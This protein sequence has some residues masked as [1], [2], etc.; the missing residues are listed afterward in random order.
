MFDGRTAEDRQ[1]TGLIIAFL[2]LHSG[3]VFMSARYRAQRP[4]QFSKGVL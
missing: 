2:S 1:T 3:A 4:P